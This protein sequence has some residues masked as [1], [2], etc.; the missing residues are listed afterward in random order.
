MVRTRRVKQTRLSFTP[1]EMS[2][3][4]GKKMEMEHGRRNYANVGLEGGGKRKRKRGSGEVVEEEDDGDVGEFCAFFG[5][6]DWVA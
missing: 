4:A 2:S 1:L 5:V 6:A 3:P